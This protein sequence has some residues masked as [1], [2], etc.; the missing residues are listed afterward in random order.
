MIWS[1]LPIAGVKQDLGLIEGF[2]FPLWGDL[3]TALKPTNK[4]DENYSSEP[5]LLSIGQAERILVKFF[6]LAIYVRLQLHAGLSLWHA[7]CKAQL[8]FSCR[9]CRG[10]EPLMAGSGSWPLKSFLDPAFGH[11]AVLS[12]LKSSAPTPTPF[13]CFSDPRLCQGN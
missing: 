1:R 9:Q 4:I 5:V 11:A 6:V 13:H 12:S 3:N 8:Y 2:Y 7:N 10:T